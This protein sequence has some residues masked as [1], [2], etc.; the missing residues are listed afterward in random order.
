MIKKHT[1]FRQ[2]LSLHDILERKLSNYLKCFMI[3]PEEN[4]QYFNFNFEMIKIVE[5]RQNI[6]YDILDR[7]VSTF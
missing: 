6:S 2:N 3:F 7:K 4:D 1:I 5:F